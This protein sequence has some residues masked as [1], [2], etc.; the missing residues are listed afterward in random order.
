[1]QRFI[2][3]PPNVSPKLSPNPIEVAPNKQRT[4]ETRV[5]RA[6]QDLVAPN[7]R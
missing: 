1:M 2:F 3:P 6:L 4:L 7:P 5:L